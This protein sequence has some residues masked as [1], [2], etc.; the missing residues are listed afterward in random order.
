MLTY[1]CIELFVSRVVAG[2]FEAAAQLTISHNRR[3]IIA[4]CNNL[5]SWPQYLLVP[6]DISTIFS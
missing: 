1:I 4:C 6:R 5:I 2:L 3:N